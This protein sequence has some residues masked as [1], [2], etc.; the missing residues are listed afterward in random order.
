MDFIKEFAVQNTNIYIKENT[1]LF[2]INR[3]GKKQQQQQ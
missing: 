2:R 3:K 1:A